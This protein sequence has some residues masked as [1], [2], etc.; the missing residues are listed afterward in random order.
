MATFEPA[1]CEQKCFLETV[2]EACIAA[3]YEA[4]FCATLRIREELRETLSYVSNNIVSNRYRT[5]DS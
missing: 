1:R 4:F 5:R 3:N 2:S